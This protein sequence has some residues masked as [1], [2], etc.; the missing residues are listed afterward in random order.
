MNLENVTILMKIVCLE[1]IIQERSLKGEGGQKRQYRKS[2]AER[3]RSVKSI[4]NTYAAS[5]LWFLTIPFKMKNMKRKFNP[6]AE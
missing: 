2:A 6:H 5:I 4:Y 1:D 3:Q